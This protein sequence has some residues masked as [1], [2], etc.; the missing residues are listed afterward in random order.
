MIGSLFF[1][2]A[3]AESG[4]VAAEPTITL[5]KSRRRTVTLRSEVKHDASFES[6]SDWGDDVRFGSKADICSAKV[7]VR[8]APESGHQN[9]PAILPSS[10]QLRQ[11][12]DIRRDPPRN[13]LRE[14]FG[15]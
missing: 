14:Q 1:F 15:R 12:G 6:L 3:P 4:Q 11:L 9:R 13:I 2:C 7:H 5:M 10:H 8:F